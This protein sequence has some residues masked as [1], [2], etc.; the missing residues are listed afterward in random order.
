MGI[1]KSLLKGMSQIITLGGASRLEKAKQAYQDTYDG[2]LILYR[3][4]ERYKAEVE[5]NVNAIKIALTAYPYTQVMLHKLN[6]YVPLLG[7]SLG[8]SRSP[9]RGS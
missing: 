6:A 5:E 3:Q 1:L 4:A 2:Y 9:A 7:R 8:A